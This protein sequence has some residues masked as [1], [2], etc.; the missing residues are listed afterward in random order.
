M[1]EYGNALLLCWIGADFNFA[2][3]PKL[4][5]R[6]CK[7][8]YISFAL[9]FF[10]FYLEGFYVLFTTKRCS[11]TSNRNTSS[12]Q[13]SAR[14]HTKARPFVASP[15][16]SAENAHCLVTTH[17]RL[18]LANGRPN[19]NAEDAHCVFMF[20]EWNRRETQ[21]GLGNYG[22]FLSCNCAWRWMKNILIQQQVSL[23]IMEGQPRSCMTAFSFGT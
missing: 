19:E 9:F 17:Y 16:D 1:R 21:H 10:L 11:I 5:L 6:L 22:L 18:C 13:Q 3:A 7:L 20:E 2:N 14:T 4:L 15:F 23:D 8:V 12:F